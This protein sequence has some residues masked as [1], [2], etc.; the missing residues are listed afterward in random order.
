MSLLDE[1]TMAEM[2][3]ALGESLKEAEAADSVYEDQ[4][5]AAADTEEQ[6][7]SSEAS[8]DVNEEEASPSETEEDVKEEPGEEGDVI[9]VQVEDSEPEQKSRQKDSKW[10]PRDRLNDVNDK[11]RQREQELLLQIGALNERAST[12]APQKSE[13]KEDDWLSEFIDSDDQQRSSSQE[14]EQLRATQTKMVQWQEDF[15]RQAIYNE[16]SRELQEAMEKYPSVPEDAFRNAVARDG[17]L[18]MLEYGEKVSAERESLVSKWRSEWETKSKS[19][20]ATEE[21]ESEPAAVRRPSRRATAS[22]PPAA[23]PETY[24]TVREAGDAMAQELADFF[25]S[26]QQ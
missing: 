6:P 17:S 19:P 3:D 7:E 15:T 24:K 12:V 14:I 10:V 26:L 4:Q 20:G 25:D 1:A 8:E 22:K 13:P 2:V 11:W 9:E 18:N 16:F 21:V 23:K 5:T